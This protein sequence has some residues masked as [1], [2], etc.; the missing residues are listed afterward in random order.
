VRGY[1]ALAEKGKPG[2]V[3]NL[4][5][6]RGIR[7]ADVL[8]MLL[9]K[10]TASIEVRPDPARQRPADLPLQ[11]GDFCRARHDLDWSPRIPLEVT[12]ADLLAD[13]RSRGEADESVGG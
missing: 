3:Y 11:V 9:D 6:G 2:R 7:I 5:S 1:L 10:T 13:W 8:R 4:C 12:L